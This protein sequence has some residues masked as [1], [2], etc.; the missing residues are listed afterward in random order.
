[1]YRSNFVP[2]SVRRLVL[3][4]LV[5]RVADTFPEDWSRDL[6][7]REVVRRWLRTEAER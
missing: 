2:K 3:L 5:D 1:M 6:T 7:V 4:A